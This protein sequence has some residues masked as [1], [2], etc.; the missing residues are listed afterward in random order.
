LSKFTG[1]NVDAMKSQW[2]T[3]QSLKIRWQ[4]IKETV[5]TFLLKGLIPVAEGFSTLIKLGKSVNET[6]NDQNTKVVNLQTHITPLL[7]RYDE[8]A[9]KANKSTLENTEMKRIISEV[10]AVMPG[11]VTAVDKYGNAIAISTG[12]VREYI[13]EEVARLKVVNRKS[14]Q[15][16]QNLLAHKEFQL[17][18]SNAKMTEISKQGYFNVEE[19]IALGRGQT[20][21]NTRKSNQEEIA[22]EQEK[23]KKLIQDINGYNAEIKRLNGD[24]IEQEIEKNEMKQYFNNMNK[25]QL[26]AWLNDEK[27]AANE[28][29]SIAQEIYNARLLSKDGGDKD[30]TDPYKA[31]LAK[32]DEELL[33]EQILLKKANKSK[34]ET[35]TEMLDIDV[36]YLTK[37]RDLYEKDS[38]EYNEYENKLLD[39]EK[40]KQIS[41]N[42]ALLKSIQDANFAKTAAIAIYEQT[43]KES[44]QQSLEDEKISQKQYNTSILALDVL[45]SEE[46]LQNATDFAALISTATYNSEEDKAKA[47]EAAT[48]AV[49]A[50]DAVLLKARQ[51][52]NRNKLQEDKKYLDKVAKLRQELGLDKEKLSYQEGLDALKA[53][54]KEAEASEKESANS[55]AAYKIKKAQ[56]YAQMANEIVN[57]VADFV[58]AKNDAEA[59][60]LEAAKQRELTAAGNNADAR[61]AIEED[62]AKKELDLKKKQADANMGI[63]I[64][65]AIADGA[66]GIANIWAKEGVNPIYAGILTALLVGITA[67]QIKSAV[68][69]RNAIKNTTLSSSNSS[70]STTATGLEDGGYVDVTRA[71]DGKRYSRTVYD[72]LRRGYIDSPTF[73]VGDGPIGQSREWVASNAAVENPTVAPLIAVMDQSQKAGTIRT[74]DMNKAIRAN[75][76]GFAEGG[77]ISKSSGSNALIPNGYESSYSKVNERLL[78]VLEKLEEEGISA[79]VSLSEFE[80]KQNLRDKSRKIG[81]KK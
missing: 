22:A 63:S 55:I 3:L 6:F 53:K 79:D 81:T 20:I 5:G 35:D 25:T 13:N 80:R 61:Q 31:R 46:R 36:R 8:L 57:A 33:A 1:G 60:S 47:V 65:Q 56:E 70:S 40:N 15:E 51:A 54:L 44:L 41:A 72:P 11:A 50:A 45:L 37:K 10:T 34:E 74:L 49:T 30:K 23:N 43:K 62:Y 71:Q 66:L 69:Q 39:I 21:I 26:V 17:K 73:L 7:S 4:E 18:E 76:A 28:Y 68:Q 29:K 2:G 32:F 27:N 12:R 58:S 9:K 24:T 64:A 19:V 42:D 67:M 59:A 77:S 52:V 14:I 75:M 48:T 16:Y 78:K 38:A